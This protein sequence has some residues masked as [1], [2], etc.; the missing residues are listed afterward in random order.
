MRQITDT[1]RI[2]TTQPRDVEAPHL[3]QEIMHRITG[4]IALGATSL[5]I[6][7]CLRYLL[8]LLD[9]NLANPFADLIYNT[10]APFL[11]VFHGL[12]RSPALIN[13]A[14]ELNT[15]IAITAYSLLAW[16]LNQL[17]RIMFGGTK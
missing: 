11:A 15:L 6:L 10:T 13:V 5:N 12:T 7:L 16:A 3:N 17:I 1:G 8:I 9:A 14:T 4:L 2:I